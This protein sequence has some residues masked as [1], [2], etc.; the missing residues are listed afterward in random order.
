MIIEIGTSDFRTAAGQKDGIF[1]E[2]I[3]EYFDALPKCK[4]E[5]VAISNVEGIAYFYHIPSSVIKELGLPN[6]IRGCNSINEPHKTILKMGWGEHVVCDE[7]PVLRIKTILDKYS[8]SEIDFLK[9][10]T[11]G[12]DAVI[13][14][15][16]LDTSKILPKKIQLD[17]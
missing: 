11:E 9:I 3:K 4:K 13:L 14:N 12:H 10:D 16:F 17:N 2:P 8:V 5:N 15:D 6:W 7:V 1:I